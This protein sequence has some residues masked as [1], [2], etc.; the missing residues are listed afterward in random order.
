MHRREVT[1]RASR[2]ASSQVDEPR[3]TSYPGRTYSFV[4]WAGNAKGQSTNT[5]SVQAVDS[6]GNRSPISSV[7]LTNQSC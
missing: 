6:T 4:M 3:L 7:T 2:G 5:F 1:S